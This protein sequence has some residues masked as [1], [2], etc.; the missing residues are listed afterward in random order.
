MRTLAIM[1]EKFKGL[2]VRPTC[3]EIDLVREHKLEI[4]ER[5]PDNPISRKLFTDPDWKSVQKARGIVAEKVTKSKDGTLSLDPTIMEQQLKQFEREVI[6]LG[7]TVQGKES[8]RIL[9]SMLH[10]QHLAVLRHTNCYFSLLAEDFKD[11]SNMPDS[12]GLSSIVTALRTHFAAGS[13]TD[14]WAAT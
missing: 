3:E 11:E 6:E 14:K 13:Q 7:W 10:D 1:E 8:C 9:W 4:E 5:S 2:H 12:S